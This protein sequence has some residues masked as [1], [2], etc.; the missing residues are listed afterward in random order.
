LPVQGK[1]VL[2]EVSLSP[3]PA[4]IKRALRIVKQRA[5]ALWVLN[6]DQ[7]LTPRLIQDGWLPGMNE[8]PWV[9][10]I[11]GAAP[12]VA[13]GT[14]FGTFALL[15]DHTALG[16]QAA[17]MILDVADNNWVLPDDME[18]EL[19][20]STVATIDLV[21][22]RE[23]FALRPD[24]LQR[25]DRVRPARASDVLTDGADHAAQPRVACVSVHALVPDLTHGRPRQWQRRRVER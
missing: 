10:A 4:E 17:G 6:D 3:N 16:A 18:V 7:L 12:L 14:N 8:R 9:P 25:V 23:R 24:A 11:A 5:D 21:Q 13:P 22:A 20:L 2:E 19:P 1:R 15:P